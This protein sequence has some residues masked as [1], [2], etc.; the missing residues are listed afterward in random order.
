M[1]IYFSPLACSLATRIALYDAG[2]DATFVEVDGP[3]KRTVDGA[4]FLPVHGLGLVPVLETD[5]G[6]RI[7]ENAAV[8]QYIASAYPRAALAP[9][10]AASITEL[11]SWLSFVG[12]EL[13]KAVYFPLLDKHASAEVRAYSLSKVDTR[14]G[15]LASQL[16]GRDFLLETFS[17]ADAYLFAVLNWS[18]VTPIVLSRWPAIDRY[19]ARLRERPSIARAVAE[20]MQLYMRELARRGE[21]LPAA[22][23]SRVSQASSANG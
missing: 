1:K 17:V 12:T 16:E 2:V 9:K 23:A 3:S 4:A 19:M 6:R 22:V 14:L 20:E 15:W 21:A 18:V 5:D 11:Q 13:H 10:D 7:T 8:L